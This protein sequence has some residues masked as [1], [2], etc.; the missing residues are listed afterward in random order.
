MALYHFRASVISRGQGQSVVAAAA[1]QARERL[2]DERTGEV[3]DYTRKTER[4]ALLFSGLYAPK[5]A[6]AWASDRAQVWNQAEAAESR[7]DAQTARRIEL[8]L[9]HELTPEQNRYALQD[10]IRETYTRKGYVVDAAIHGPEAGGDAR[11]LHAHLLISLRTLDA[12]GFSPTKDRSQNSRETLAQWREAWAKTA[13]RHLE[14]HGHAAR[15]DHRSLEA[16]GVAREPTQH[17]GP[18]ATQIEREGKR[19]ERGDLNREIADGNRAQQA[20]EQ[21]QEALARE[22]AALEAQQEAEA[23]E[24]AQREKLARLFGRRAQPPAQERPQPAPSPYRMEQAQGPTVALWQADRGREAKTPAQDWNQTAQQRRRQ[25][26]EERQARIDAEL[27]ARHQQ[28]EQ[29]RGLDDERGLGLSL[30][31]EFTRPREPQP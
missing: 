17:L 28:R 7:K 13:N 23:H 29:D 24:Q 14:R 30:G 10:F 3:K 26:A 8:A 19:S 11:N 12:H 5:N 20:R 18:T 16:Q 31:D 21:E 9:P 1:Y 6:P 25:E 2:R 27:K 15:I 22:V 4:Q